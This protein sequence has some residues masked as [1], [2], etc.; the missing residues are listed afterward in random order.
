VIGKVIVEQD[1]SRCAGTGLSPTFLRS[2]LREAQGRGLDCP[3]CDGTGKEYVTTVGGKSPTYSLEA[4]I[5]LDV[6]A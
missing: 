1:C 6:P 3:A 4:V 5:Y 2:I